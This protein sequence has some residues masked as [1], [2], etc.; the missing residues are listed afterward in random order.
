MLLLASVLLENGVSRAGDNKP[1]KVFMLV[2]QSNMQGHA[3]ITTFEHIGM[4]PV[5]APLLAD[6]PS[7]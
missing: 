3:R 6:M 7:K 1:L 4:N 2:G 5:T